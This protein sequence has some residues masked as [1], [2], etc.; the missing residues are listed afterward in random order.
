M[1]L[2]KILFKPGVNR[3]NT[4]YTTEG[5]WYD[6]DKVRFRQG[7]PEKLGGWDEISSARYEGTC[8]SLWSWSSL[9]GI[10]WI[11]VGTNLKYYIE[12]GLNYYDVTPLRATTG[13]TPLSGP[14]AATTGSTTVTVTDVAHGSSTGDFV[15]F[16]GAIALSTQ[17]YTADSG[18]DFITFTTAL[19]NGT[20]LEV[21]TTGT[22][23]GGLSADT[24]YYVINATGTT[25]QLALSNGGA[26]IN[27][28][29]AGTGTQTLAL[30]TGITAAVLN[31]NFQMTVIDNDT[32]TIE[33]SVAATAYDTGTGGSSV[34]A[35][36][37][38]PAG[39]DVSTGISGWG[40]GTWGAGTW[41]NGQT[42][43]QPPRLWNANNFGQDLIAGYR[44]GPL[45][46]WNASIGPQQTALTTLDVESQTFTV[47]IA[48]PAVVTWVGLN[49]LPNGTPVKLTT[50][51]ALP[52]GLVAGTTYFVVNAGTDG[53]HKCRLSA[54]LGGAD[55]NTSGS[56]SGTQT[57]QSP[58]IFGYAG[59]PRD[60]V[61]FT[62][63]TS[64]VL[65]TG[66][67]TGQLYYVVQSDDVTNTFQLALTPN[68]T[69]IIGT[70]S[71]T[72]TAYLSTRM[73]PVSSLAFSDGYCP[74]AQNYFL[75]SDASRFT[76]VFGTNEIGSTTIDPM[77]IRWSD[78]ESLTVWY[79]EAT[80]QA[81]FLRLSHG[82]EIVTALQVRQ[83]ILV[84]TDS[85]LY[86]MQYLGAPYV[87]GTQLLMDN[88]SIVSQNAA[89]LAS[90][91]TYWMGLDK[92]YKYDGRVQ[93]MRCDLR[94]YIFQDINRAQ[95]GQVFS[96]TNEGFNEVW[97][98][99]CSGTSTTIDKYVVYNYAED[100]WYYGTM[101]RTAWSDSALNG[102]P[103]AATY[104]HNLVFHEYGNNDNVTGTPA[105][106]N[107]YITSS[108]F[109]IGDGHNFGFVWRLLP[110]V[111]FR[112]STVASPDQPT[113]TM[114][115]IPLKNSG[116]GYSTPPSVGGSD[117]EPVVQT[118][119]GTAIQVEEFTQQ[120]NVRVRGRQ[121]SFKIE[122]DQLGC[123]WQ[124]GAP[125]MDIRPDGRR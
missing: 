20:T 103:I 14:F 6:C 91:V 90:G 80:N 12:Q 98:F 15:S 60:A 82:S 16:R 104:E 124:L 39:V 30:E 111:T 4:R 55:I 9:S 87:W 51:G 86:S 37:E 67:T 50:T 25:C 18:T 53:L 72:G 41:G 46:Y 44:G 109:D 31:S 43:V 65:P 120:I 23:P 83:E 54:T 2:Q 69:A 35:Y 108:E 58:T 114:Y 121:I 95:F 122:S 29:S 1:P 22:A 56:Q 26:P 125:R 116:S 19:P 118:Q 123:Q 47:T 3:E 38:I 40:S 28:S 74:V 88:V 76:I 45:Y 107:A 49:D 66:F 89:S 110:D 81:G 92:F 102:Y 78:Q 64:G 96:G 61:T 33:V 11:G 42:S 13:N 34:S 8:R 105:P 59:L 21:F 75:V 24:R 100:I 48:S 79:P 84:W 63:E 10:D 32:Y 94:Q 101:E 77:L 93:T 112:G 17:T 73:V 106:M 62:L 119:A 85:A 97:W 7:T 113:V 117:N 36:Y 27:I 99:Y 115:M 70:G 57:M 68:G 71:Y 5:G 52:T